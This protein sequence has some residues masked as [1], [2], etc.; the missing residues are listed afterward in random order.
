LPPAAVNRPKKVTRSEMSVPEFPLRSS[1]SPDEP[2]KVLGSR[3]MPGWATHASPCSEN[4]ITVM[5]CTLLAAGCSR[6]LPEIRDEIYRIR[7]HD[8][9]KIGWGSVNS[10]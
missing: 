5:V 2:V 4:T 1:R 9:V 8:G 10:A 7:C 3:R 6:R